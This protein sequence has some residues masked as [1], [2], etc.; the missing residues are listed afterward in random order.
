MLINKRVGLITNPTGVTSEFQSTIDVLYNHPA[1]QLVALFGPEHGVRGNYTAGEKIHGEMDAITG[2]PVYSLYGQT[3]KPTP[4]ML[5][6]IDVLLYD[7]Q[8]IG[9][10]TYTYI[11]T[12]A[13]AMQAAKE[14]NIPFIVL[15]RPNPLGGERINGPV[16]DPKFR[17]FIGLYPIPYIYGMT[18]GEIA[19][20]FNTEYNIH[21]DLSVITMQGWKRNMTFEDTGLPWVPTSTHIPH[22]STPL[23]YVATGIAGEL[24][25]INIGVGYTIPFEMVAAPWIDAN[26]FAR[27]LN[28]KDLPGVYFRAVHYKPFY[29][30]FMGTHVHGIHIH[31]MDSKAFNPILIQIHI[32]TTLKKLYPSQNIFSTQRTDM[33]DK[34]A[35]TDQLRKMIQQGMDAKSIIHSWQNDLIKFKQI[36]KRYLYYK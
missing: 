8:D 30:H 20:L 32:L 22:M 2:V 16:L 12:M 7:I 15:D 10:R 23:Y 29:S 6:N 35:G 21:A 26:Q 1:V 34:A 13:Y 24:D 25:T 36:W 11:Y 33:F 14:H 3:K 19:R 31:I 28:S 27:M 17:S 5:K 4:E 18:C 9:C